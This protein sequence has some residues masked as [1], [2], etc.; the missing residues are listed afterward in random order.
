M[1]E[2]IYTALLAAQREMP[3]LQKSGINPHFRNRYVPLEELISAVVPVL[4]KY[5]I[6]LI[7]APTYHE[8]QPALQTILRCN[9]ESIEATMPLLCAKD[10]PQGQGSAITYA[11][12]YS[13]MAMLGLSADEDDDAEK[14]TASKGRGDQ[15]V[16]ESVPRPTPKGGQERPTVNGE[17]IPPPQC[18]EHGSMTYVKAGTS[19]AGKPY[20][21]FWS[22]PQRR[23]GC[24]T[25][26][27]DAG[28]WAAEHLSN[29]QP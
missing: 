6:V 4:N 5:G 20:P 12:R 23:E 9:G 11:R 27:V 22:C 28:N 15:Y 24:R 10:D 18:E 3:A 29:Q 19:K 2:S 21:A 14:A 16:H 1:T 8:G 17:P 26:T 7:Q 25:K 13:L